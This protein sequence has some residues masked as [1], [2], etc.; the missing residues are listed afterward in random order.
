MKRIFILLFLVLVPLLAFADSMYSPTWGFR[1]NLPE[2]YAYSEGDGKDR[3]SFE[4]PEGARFDIIV[5]NGAYASIKDLAA[6]VNKRLSNKG[7]SDFFRYNNKEAAILE[8]KFGNLSG[9]GICVELAASSGKTP[10]LVALA[11]GPANKT[12]LNVFHLSALDSIVPSDAEQL[13]PGP[14]IDYSYPRGAQKNTALGSSGVSAMIRENDAEAA[15]VLV[16]REFVVLTTYVNTPMWKE[17]WIRYYRMIYRDSY[18]RVSDAAAAL[19]SS[20]GG[21]AIGNDEAKIAFAQKALTFVQ[22]FKYERNPETS[23]FLN[24]VSA[25]TEGRGDCDSRAMLWAIFLS[26]ANIRSAMMVSP[27]YS[28]AMGLADISGVGARF[29]A[30]QTKWLVAETTDKVKIGLIAKDVSDPQHWFGILFE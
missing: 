15:Q 11:Y 25:V 5:Y 4:G 19:V 17:A 1:L 27:H 21:N 9:L 13:Y 22:G 7:E 2:G 29:D 18:D 14:I 26:N 12:A 30:Y 16:E 23:D 6:D 24:L 20:W 3:F 28:H 10:L 8:L